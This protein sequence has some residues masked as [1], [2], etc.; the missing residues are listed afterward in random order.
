MNDR[1]T[2]YVKRTRWQPCKFG[3][4]VSICYHT[5]RCGPVRPGDGTFGRYRAGWTRV[6][7]SAQAFREAGAWA[8]E[9]WTTRIFASTRTVRAEV[10]AWERTAKGHPGETT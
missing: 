10:R 2:Y 4:R 3:D 8:A 1:L 7:G 9:G 6:R 5:P